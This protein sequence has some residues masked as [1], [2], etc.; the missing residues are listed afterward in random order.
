M[1]YDNMDI[2]I[3]KLLRPLMENLKAKAIYL[4]L[5]AG[6]VLLLCDVATAQRRKEKQ[7]WGY[8]AAV[9]YNFQADGFG[10][11]LR[12]KIPIKGR[13]SLVPEFNY[14]PDF[15]RYHEFY[16]GGALHL[17]LLTLRSYNFYILGGGYYNKWINAEV[18]APG[19]RK[20]ENFVVE[21]GGGLV[22]NRGCIRPFI[23]DR[24]D[25]KWKEDNL[26]IGIYWYPG[27]CGGG[28]RKEPCPA[29]D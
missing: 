16:A 4:I 2:Y 15:N 10:G 1:G 18:Y 23:E 3:L 27:Q 9:I 12:M 25:F 22:R 11:D 26:R 5:C 24:W 7:P 29:Y 21:A 6:M 14:Y 17:E 20:R 13:L 19:Q 8:G 28:R